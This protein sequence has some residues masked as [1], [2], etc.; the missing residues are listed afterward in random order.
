VNVS[1]VPVKASSAKFVWLVE[2]NWVNA[3]H[4]SDKTY[5]NGADY[6]TPVCDVAVIVNV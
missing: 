4:G 3:I 2:S 6:S 1:A 5:V